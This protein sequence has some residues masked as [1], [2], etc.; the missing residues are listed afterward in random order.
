[1]YVPHNLAKYIKLYTPYV[2]CIEQTDIT[3]TL[4]YQVTDVLFWVKEKFFIV[5]SS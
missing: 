1:M 4:H 5:A 3:C 2:V